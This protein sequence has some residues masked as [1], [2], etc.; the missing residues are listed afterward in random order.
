MTY[1]A[2]QFTGEIQC[3]QA[4]LLGQNRRDLLDIQSWHV[5]ISKSLRPIFKEGLDPTEGTESRGLIKLS[6]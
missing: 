2:S 5:V 4:Y 1:R 3:L 6:A